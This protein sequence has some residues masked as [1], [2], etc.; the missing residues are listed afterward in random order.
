M[1]NYDG[2]Y[3]ERGT[4]GGYTQLTPA[5]LY[6]F[7]SRATD[8]APAQVISVFDDH[9]I[10]LENSELFNKVLGGYHGGGR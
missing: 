6:S 1:G 10:Q 3:L 2:K 9:G 7:V 8:L 4:D 5:W